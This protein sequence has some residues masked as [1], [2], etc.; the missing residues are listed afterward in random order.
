MKSNLDSA[1]IGTYT[2]IYSL[3]NKSIT[4]TI[5]VIEKPDIIT[6]IHLTGEKNMN[7]KLDEEFS[8]P[9]YKAIDAIDGDLTDQVIV[10]GN[11]DT[12]QKGT[13]KI[14]YSVINSAGV[15][16]FETRTIVVE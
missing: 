6:V 14:V 5:N 9:G 13:Y 8:E 4:R 11:V 7:L 10:N 2:I 3:N 16:T 12:S 15:T 1:S